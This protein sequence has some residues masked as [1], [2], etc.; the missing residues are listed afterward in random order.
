MLF[1]LFENLSV[2]T[3]LKF[4]NQNYRPHIEITM[5]LSWLLSQIFHMSY[6]IG[7]LKK[8]YTD[9]EDL[10]NME[11]RQCKVKDI[12]DKMKILSQIRKYL[13]LGLVRFFGDFILSCYDLKLF[14]N[15]LGTK[16]M[17]FV[18]GVTGLIS[19]TISLYQQFFSP[20]F[21]K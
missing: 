19:A 9:E 12:Y 13:F 17:K 16:I 18:V 15:F 21:L 6:Y 5:S 1:Y 14:E 7:I 3:N 4:I 8:T 2:L 20:P 11:V 10:R